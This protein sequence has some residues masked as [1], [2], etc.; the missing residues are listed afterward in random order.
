MGD[1]DPESAQS[2][3]LIGR[4]I[5]NYVIEAT[6]G[7]GGMG[8]VYKARHRLLDRYA[9]IKVMHLSMAQ[10]SS[11]QARFRREARSAAALRH[12]H[13]VE[14]FDFDE[15]D[16]YAYL[17]MELVSGGTLRQLLRDGTARDPQ[18]SLVRG[19][20][21][22]RQ[23]S[24]ALAYAHALG[25][26][27]RDIKP[28][29]LLLQEDAQQGL[30]L[31]IGDF[32]LARMTVSTNDS[33]ATQAGMAL[34]TLAYMAPEQAAGKELD[35]RA[36]MY[37]LGIILYELAT[38]EPP[39]VIKTIT[40]AVFKHTFVPP[41]MPRDKRPDLSA[42]LEGLI[43]RCLAKLPEQR[44]ASAADLSVALRE[45]AGTFSSESDAARAAILPGSHTQIG[46]VLLGGAAR[47]APEAHSLIGE[48]ALPRI[49]V[50]DESG[51]LLQVVAVRPGGMSVGRV[52]ANDLQLDAINIS[53]HHLQ[54]TWDGIRVQ[55]IDLGSRIGSQINGT[56]LVPQVA[57]EWPWGTL[58]QIGTYWLRIDA[59]T[60]RQQAMGADLPF[61][62]PAPPESTALSAMFNSQRSFVTTGEV[63]L[64]INPEALTLTPG[65]NTTVDVT[66]ANMSNTTDQLLLSVNGVPREWVVLP[67][68]QQIGPWGQAYVQITIRVP[69]SSAATAGEYPVEV[70]ATSQLHPQQGGMVLARWAV[71]PFIQAGVVVTTQ[72]NEGRGRSNYH[73]AVRN[74]GNSAARFRLSGSAEDAQ[75]RFSFTP[76]QLMIEPGATEN[77]QLQID[78]SVPLIGRK[79]TSP[80]EI[81]LRNDDGS[82]AARGSARLM[83]QARISGWMLALLALLLI[84][85]IA[86]AATLLNT[87]NQTTVASSA[88]DLRTSV[89]A[90]AEQARQTSQA[91]NA[92]QAISASPV[93]SPS[94]VSTIPPTS[95]A[96]IVGA[97]AMP[98][99]P[100]ATAVEQAAT[101]A[102]NQAIAVSPTI[103]PSP[104][105][106][107]AQSPT[108]TPVPTIVLLPTSTPQ[109]FQ[110]I[111]TPTLTS[112]PTASATATRVP[113]ATN[114]AIPPTGTAT[115]SATPLPTSTATP[116]GTAT[117]TN[118]PTLTPTAT[119]TLTPTPT[120]TNTA[121]PT[122]GPIF[123]LGNPTTTN[124]AGGPG[125]SPYALLC[126]DGSVATGLTGGAGGSQVGSVSGIQVI[127]NSVSS[128]FVVGPSTT[129]QLAGTMQGA[130]FTLLCATGSGMTGATGMVG[131]NGAG[132]V[133]QLAILCT[134]L[135]PLNGTGVTSSPAVGNVFP[136][137]LAFTL[138]C[139][140]TNRFVTGVQGHGGGLIDQ[141]QLVC[142]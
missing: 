75:A 138:N 92:T 136:G 78:S 50:L 24:D 54:V 41:P 61:A 91:G 70:R 28:E 33:V 98:L 36:D 42:A 55:V 30:I 118:T 139:P 80:F 66:L 76:D 111:N 56:A 63:G 107:A 27:H 46:T 52:A 43:L 115:P 134:P 108:S 49:Q 69:P 83:R 79:T 135:N 23:A 7:I 34:G 125:G 6:L 130:P 113:T 13:I 4:T 77:A 137:A 67:P 59:P 31:K 26:V 128:N 88:I 45:V 110:G 22:I 93:P 129:T 81:Q 65:S 112:V 57:T 119:S 127:C 71:R 97:T 25:M 109:L 101:S 132:V 117:P 37:A 72:Q 133:D 12:P 126:P 95:V 3:S 35:G 123:S 141:I 18:W 116:T 8:E 73:I 85:G 38:G 82:I 68:A 10:D 39:F 121:T 106:V 86:G 5:G 58:L 15:A 19:L 124:P 14:V 103:A 29:N 74:D 120:P 2:P 48:T 87:G 89:A 16:G 64:S 96:T 1:A 11:F 17:V 100:T 60:T 105:P 102:P 114:T 94:Q 32:G 62:A 84:G 44:F 40:E 104:S 21:L 47:Q 142:R 90:T 20:D 131:N 140:T 53:R 122:T 9:A 51:T 99:L